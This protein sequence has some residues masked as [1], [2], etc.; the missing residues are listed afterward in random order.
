MDFLFKR[1]HQF[2]QT[3]KS[4]KQKKREKRT[5]N[6]L[7]IFDLNSVITSLI[8]VYTGIAEGI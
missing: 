1:E 8:A 7:E 2:H 6:K 5:E 3:W 4:F